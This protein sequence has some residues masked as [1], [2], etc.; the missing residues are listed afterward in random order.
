M[1]IGS[2]H[3]KSLLLLFRKVANGI[4]GNYKVVNLC[5]LERTGNTYDKIPISFKLIAIRCT[6]EEVATQNDYG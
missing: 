4:F 2:S 6:K 1:Y 3:A 5:I